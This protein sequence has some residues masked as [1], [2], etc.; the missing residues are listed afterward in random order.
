[1][2]I[3]QGPSGRV[4]T[5]NLEAFSELSWPARTMKTMNEQRAY[6]K[7]L[8]ELPGS[9]VVGRYLCTAL[10]YSVGTGGDPRGIL[11]EWNKKINNEIKAR[12]Q[13]FNM[14]LGG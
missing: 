8:P 9:Y 7:G 11:Y 12:R 2:E 6:V 10:R 1:M 4:P 14:N 13:E 3:L 5:A